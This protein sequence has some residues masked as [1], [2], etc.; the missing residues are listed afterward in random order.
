MKEDILCQIQLRDIQKQ[1][2]TKEDLMIFLT[3]Q[4]LLY[5]PNAMNLSYHIAHVPT[6]APIKGGKLFPS[7]RFLERH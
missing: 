5:V 3:H 6:A 1:G 4:Q 7:K 2:E